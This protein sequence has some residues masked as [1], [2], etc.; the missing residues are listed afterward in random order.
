[1]SKDLR[2]IPGEESFAVGGRGGGG[3]RSAAAKRRTNRDPPLCFHYASDSV[4][5][6]GRLL[7]GGT[8]EVEVEQIKQQREEEAGNYGEDVNSGTVRY[9][10]PCGEARHLRIPSR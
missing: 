4:I 9:L 3:A 6:A 10:F 7:L 1:M 2:I 8:A 5:A